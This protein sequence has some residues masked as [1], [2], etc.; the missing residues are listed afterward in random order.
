MIDNE[1]EELPVVDKD[2]KDIIE[3]IFVEIEIS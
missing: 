1:L 2:L 3:K